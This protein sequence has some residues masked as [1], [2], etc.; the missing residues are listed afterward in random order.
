MRSD[1]RGPNCGSIWAL[2][3]PKYPTTFP[4]ASGYS[5]PRLTTALLSVLP[6]PTPT[7]F[8]N[9][10]SS[11][12]PSPWLMSCGVLF[13]CCLGNQGHNADSAVFEWPRRGKLDGGGFDW[14]GEQWPRFTHQSFASSWRNW[15]PEDGQRLCSPHLKSCAHPRGKQHTGDPWRLP[16]DLPFRSCQVPP[17]PR[18]SFSSIALQPTSQR[19][20]SGSTLISTLQAL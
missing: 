8:A 10:P 6:W 15:T 16:L 20:K 13:V 4:L 3:A 12:M 17:K 7:K 1:W 19:K 14:R 2:F 9:P 11:P 18:P 5:A